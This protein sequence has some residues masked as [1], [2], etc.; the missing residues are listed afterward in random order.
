MTEQ[1]IF[2]YTFRKF[3]L[4]LVLTFLITLS[5]LCALKCC[6]RI[7]LWWPVIAFC[8][9][10][11]LCWITWILLY[12][13]K[14]KML[15]ITNKNIKIDHCEPLAWKDIDHAEIRF[16]RYCLCKKPIIA[17]VPKKKIK[18]NYNLL[19][20]QLMKRGCDFPPF[21][22]P[23]YEIVSPYDAIEIYNI[24]AEKTKFK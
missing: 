7:F 11:A 19:Q 24:I 5:V 2:Y 12:V 14:H 4:H 23:L 20:K 13:V 9:A 17:L 3:N 8:F 16:V 6:P 18:Y 10:L 1:K 21:S 22:I 15:V